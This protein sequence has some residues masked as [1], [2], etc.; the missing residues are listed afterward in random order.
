VDGKLYRKNAKQEI[1]QKCVST[2]EGKKILEEIHSGTCGNHVASRTLVGKAFQVGFYWPSAVADAE[3]YVKRCENYQF[4]AKQI[5]V[6]AQVLVGDH[7]QQIYTTNKSPKR[8]KI[9]INTHTY[10]Y[11]SVLFPLV[12]VELM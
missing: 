8:R 5:H 7:Y 2:G 6:Q 9:H 3:D 4:F 1:L 10:I 11:V 12:P